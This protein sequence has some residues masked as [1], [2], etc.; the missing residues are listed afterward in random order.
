MTI[1]RVL[2]IRHGETEWNH[3]GRWQGFEQIPLNEVGLSQA[4]ALAEHLRQ[5][6][7]SAIYSSDLL[8]ALQTANPLC[9][10]LGLTPVAH[11]DWREQ[12][13]GIFQ[14]LTRD[15]IEAKYPAELASMRA[16]M[17]Y[18]VPKGESRADMQRRAHRAWEAVV[19]NGNGPEVTVVSHGGT[20]KVLLMKLFGEVPE[21]TNVYIPNTSITAVERH[22]SGWRLVEIGA[23]AH[24][25]S[26]D[27]REIEGA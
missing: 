17:T 25:I 23:T 2:L 19:A 3:I 12:N 14:G 6:S 27:G 15:E 26:V 22:E 21:V 4:K 7:I 11:A 1:E 5:R 8:R 18:V 16:D 9:E 24:L 20:I 10:A 13:L